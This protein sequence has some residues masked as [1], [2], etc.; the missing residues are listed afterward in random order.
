MAQLET[1]VVGVGAE[2]LRSAPV[3]GLDFFI[4]KF[5]GEEEQ[6]KLAVKETLGET[7]ATLESAVEEI[8]HA[9]LSS[10]SRDKLAEAIEESVEQPPIAGARARVVMARYC[11]IPV[12]QIDN[13]EE[14]MRR[15][16]LLRT[17]THHVWLENRLAE[18]L[19]SLGYAVEIGRELREGVAQFWVDIEGKRALPPVHQVKVDIIC[20]Q[21]P[22]DHGLAALL[23]DMETSNL[24]QEGDWFLVATHGIFSE[25]SRSTVRAARN[26]VKYILTRVEGHDI[27]D[28]VQAEGDPGKLGTLLQSIVER[29]V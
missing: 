3:A 4:K 9:P 6:A 14:W 22:I 11:E 24:L 27:A 12:N 28:M 7:R 29:P 20:S 21:P 19:A 1:L 23:Y 16:D 13:A 2:L 26:R 5:H 8:T 17:A 18:S 15:A 25:F 10:D